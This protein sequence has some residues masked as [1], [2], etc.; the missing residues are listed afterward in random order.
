MKRNFN[1]SI[2]N[3]IYPQVLGSSTMRDLLNQMCRN[4]SLIAQGAT[5]RVL[6]RDNRE[7][8]DT[9]R[10]AEAK[11]FVVGL[12]KY[13]DDNLENLVEYS[14]YLAFD[15]DHI[16]ETAAYQT[17]FSALQKWEY[18]FLAFPSLSGKGIRL[19]VETN[20]T[21]ET[22]KAVY[23]SICQTLK[24]YLQVPLKVEEK[25]RLKQLHPDWSN[26]RVEQ[27]LKS[28]LFID[29]GCSNLSRLWFY[30]GI[31]QE[32]I[33]LNDDAQ[34][35]QYTAPSVQPNLLN[36]P[37]PAPPVLTAPV[38]QPNI[39]NTPT[40]QTLTEWDKVVD[41]VNQIERR[42]VDLTGSVV[43]W[44]RVGVALASEFGEQGRDLFHR[45]AKF[46][47]DYKARENDKEFNRHLRK[48]GSG[49][50]KIATFYY[51]CKENGITFD[52][53]AAFQ[54]HFQQSAP[55]AVTGADLNVQQG[56]VVP[57]PLP[58]FEWK[59]ER[60]VI[61]VAMQQVLGFSD[62]QEVF[63]EF[64]VDYFKE[65]AHRLLA[66]SILDLQESEQGVNPISVYERVQKLVAYEYTEEIF[67]LQL[68]AALQV[69]RARVL[70]N[71]Y[72]EGELAKLTVTVQQKIG[73]GK[74]QI[75]EL[76]N[77][78]QQGIEKLIEL[79]PIQ[80]DESLSETTKKILEELEIKSKFRKE[81]NADVI[82]GVSSGL[83]EEDA[84][85]DGCQKSDLIILAARPG[86]GKTAKILHMANVNVAQGVSGGMF[87]LEM[88]RNQLVMRMISQSAGISGTALRRGDLQDH[89]WQ[90]LKAA[91]ENLHDCDHLLQIDDSA[92]L[93][94]TQLIAKARKWKKNF[95]IQYLIVDYLQLITVK[96]KRSREEAVSFISRSL[97]QLA[98]EL[99]IPVIAL[100]QLSRAVETRGGSK[101]PQ[102]SDLRES[103]GIEQDADIVAF[104]YRP[105]YY[106][107]KEDEEGQS[108]KGI[109][110]IIVAKHRNGATKT[111]K[112][113]FEAE[114]TRFSDLSD[115]MAFEE[116]AEEVVVAPTSLVVHPS[117]NPN[118]RTAPW[119]E[120]YDPTKD[121]F[122]R[123]MNGK[124]NDGDV[125]F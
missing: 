120:G 119:E 108:L 72:R 53:R 35:F 49:R 85:L 47:P 30:S 40:Y 9:Q 105:E 122:N 69:D 74:T 34:V 123:S 50:I 14:P 99:E 33:Y 1:I 5:F 76:L 15:I 48:S 38:V 24:N 7:L 67:N 8:Y 27:E 112:V 83:R 75:T 95:D 45:V 78:T 103:G 65:E 63:P 66:Q 113:R 77:D 114:Y 25:E 116:A 125:P 61:S 115:D 93:T 39:S 41:L 110:E 28:V 46:H 62:I 98:K 51:L 124:R 80:I 3:G 23:E 107:I 101:R 55:I 54:H 96:G 97:K 91:M 32:E 20:A 42:G 29:S 121:P 31:P 100:S 2:V 92:G 90:Q 58:S 81:G 88:A 18:A 22:H 26:A 57:T 13:R 84:L 43:E 21:V 16:F 12:W 89:E 117:S 10:K 11:A 68:D 59:I 86:M 4:K 71:R 64:N 94:I 109:A 118:D 19:F 60:E 37:A 73:E 6:S 104:V 87:S 102:L 56:M 106:G 111:V 52:Y 44:F 79:E 70:A 82:S 17:I 36:Q